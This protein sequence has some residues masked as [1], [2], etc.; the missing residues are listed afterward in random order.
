MLKP[1]NKIKSIKWW[2]VF[3]QLPLLPFKLVPG[4]RPKKRS[5]RSYRLQLT[6]SK[7]LIITIRQSK[8]SKPKQ[9]LVSKRTS[10]SPLYLFLT[11]DITLWRKTS[12]QPKRKTGKKVTLLR[13]TSYLLIFLGLAGTL[14]FGWQARKSSN[15]E[16]QSTFSVAIPTPAQVTPRTLPHSEPTH[17]TISSVGID[18]NVITVGKNADG[19]IETPPVLS[20]ET[21]WYKYGPTPGELGPAVIVGHVDSYKGISVFWQLHEV[22]PG[23]EIDITRV[24]GKIVKFKVDALKQF[25]QANFPTQE[26]YG[27]IDYA[28]LRLITCGGTFNTDT[29]HYSENTVVYASLVT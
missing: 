20:D 28:G 25:D 11:K 9:K 7:E 2:Q 27:N 21:G 19:T 4:K 26:V 22:Q 18:A 29:G 8:V 5:P 14:Y 13:W 16:P 10:H 6:S 1:L 3:N 17:L 23:D 15:I 12:R 24:D